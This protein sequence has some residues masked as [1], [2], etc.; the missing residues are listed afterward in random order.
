VD[1]IRSWRALQPEVVQPA[2]LPDGLIE[3][4]LEGHEE[5]CYF[6][7]EIATYADRRVQEQIV[8]G[9]LLSFVSRRVLPDALVVVLHPRARTDV[10][11]AAEY[12]SR[13]GWTDLHVRWRL[14]KL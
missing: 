3:A 6:L 12:L 14:L 11:P 2:Q 5:P 13:R 9:A 4:W 10:R 7:I 1:A 8:R